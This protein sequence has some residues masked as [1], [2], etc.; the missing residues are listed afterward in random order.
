MKQ[1]SLEEVLTAIKYCEQHVQ[2]GYLYLDKKKI[3]ISKNFKVGL[4]S[5]FKCDV[6]GVTLSYF[7][8]HKEN[9]SFYLRAHTVNE[10]IFTIEHIVPQ[11]VGGSNS[12]YNLTCTCSYC[13]F[14]WKNKF[15][16]QLKLKVIGISKCGRYT[17]TK[18]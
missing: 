5:N 10:R 7:T 15:D 11:S 1:Y 8:V 16:K 4:R 2:K 14:V 13:N 9:N 12:N 6:C 18:V 17:L 3:K